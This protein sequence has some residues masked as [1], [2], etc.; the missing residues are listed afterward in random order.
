[1]EVLKFMK[2]SSKNLVDLSKK[3]QT[4][5]LRKLIEDPLNLPNGSDFISSAPVL[6]DEEYHRFCLE[7]AR[8]N[9]CQKNR[10]EIEK[11]LKNF[12][13]FEIKD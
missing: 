1:M 2:K 10:K 6:S 3:E 9:D 5:L 4:D 12:V 13:P 8:Y 7:A 11:N